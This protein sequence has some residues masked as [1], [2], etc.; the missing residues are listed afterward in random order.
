MNVR[1]MTLRANEYPFDAD[2]RNGD[3]AAVNLC[4]CLHVTE[5][6]TAIASQYRCKSKKEQ[7]TKIEN[8]TNAIKYPGMSCPSEVR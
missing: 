5:W 1:T 2:L 6:I 8:L 3:A 4:R 7:S